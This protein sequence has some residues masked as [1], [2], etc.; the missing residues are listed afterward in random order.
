MLDNFSVDELTKKVNTYT[1]CMLKRNC[2]PHDIYYSSTWCYNCGYIWMI[3]SFYF[4][5]KLK[6]IFHKWCDFFLWI[7]YY[8]SL[9]IICLT[10]LLYEWKFWFFFMFVYQLFFIYTYKAGNK[11]NLNW[12]ILVFKERTCSIHVNRN[13]R[14]RFLF[15][16]KKMFFLFRSY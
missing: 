6:L 14:N 7:L 1:F 13:S 8:F 11:K 4:L 16:I 15:S 5:T 2:F 10:K 9:S 3:K 12:L